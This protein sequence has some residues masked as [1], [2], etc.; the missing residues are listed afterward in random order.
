MTGAKLR[1]RR[2]ALGLSQEKLAQLLGVS[3]NT[4]ARWER[5]ELGIRHPAMLGRAL[6]ALVVPDR[7]KG[8]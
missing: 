3:A 4:I 7:R 6:D 8:A 5:G 1:Q 2:L